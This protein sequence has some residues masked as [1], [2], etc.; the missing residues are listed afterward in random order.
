MA[1]QRFNQPAFPQ[2]EMPMNP[3]V[4]EP[5]QSVHGLLREKLFQFVSRHRSVIVTTLFVNR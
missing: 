4:R 3:S 5:M 1:Q 2:A